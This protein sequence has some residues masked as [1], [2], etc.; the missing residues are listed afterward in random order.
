MKLDSRFQ[1]VHGKNFLSFQISLCSRQEILLDL[2]VQTQYSFLEQI[3][4]SISLSHLVNR[5]TPLL[6]K[7]Y[8]LK[9][10]ISIGLINVLQIC[11]LV[12]LDT[13]LNFMA[14]ANV[15]HLLKSNYNKYDIKQKKQ[16]DQKLVF[17]ITHRVNNVHSQ[18][19]TTIQNGA[20]WT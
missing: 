20:G 14:F 15:Y 1:C 8:A 11:N 17:Q 16:K 13:I 18:R 5:F 7:R 9:A 12:F 19:S 4:L 10:F 2:I 3:H 6:L